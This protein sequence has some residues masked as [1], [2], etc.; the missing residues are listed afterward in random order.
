MWCVA[1]QRISFKVL[2][3]EANDRTSV[4]ISDPRSHASEE[5]FR[6]L[7]IPFGSVAC[8][9]YKF[10]GVGRSKISESGYE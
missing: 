10:E 1:A 8:G 5:Y 6:G 4:N 2:A 3:K 9:K 7:N